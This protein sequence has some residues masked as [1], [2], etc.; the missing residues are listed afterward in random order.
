MSP[1]TPLAVKLLKPQ[2]DVPV[3]FGALLSLE[4]LQLDGPENSIA[5]V[6]YCLRDVTWS[7]F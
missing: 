2:S 6:A 7:S 5:A 1:P 3:L 4:V